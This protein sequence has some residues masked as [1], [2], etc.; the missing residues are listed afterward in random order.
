MSSFM[1][2]YR[3]I[4]ILLFT[5][6]RVVDLRWA[7]HKQV[8]CPGPLETSGVSCKLGQAQICIET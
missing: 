2:R 3:E 7:T 4:A 8:N 6:L 5:C 1:Y